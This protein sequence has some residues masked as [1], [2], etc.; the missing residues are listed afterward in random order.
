[1]I[2]TIWVTVKFSDIIYI[3]ILE[4]SV[5]KGDKIFKLIKLSPGFFEFFCSE[6]SVC[7]VQGHIG[8]RKR[9]MQF[10]TRNNMGAMAEVEKLRTHSSAHTHTYTCE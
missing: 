7:E 5:V 3:S 10:R 9:F 1:M 4:L 2:S 8:S 6:E